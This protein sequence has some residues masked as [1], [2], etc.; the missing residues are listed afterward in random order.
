MN[1]IKRKRCAVY[2]R[3]SS[4]ERLD[5]SFNSIDA[6]REAGAAYVTSQKAEGWELIPEF[7][8]DPGFSGGN[9][10]RPGLKQLLTDIQASKIDIVVVYKIDRLSRS[11]ADF[12]KMVEVFD[13]QSVSF[14]S[15]TQQINSATSMGRLMLNVLLSFAQF[16]RE[17]TGERIRDKI[18]A[19]KRKGM[20]MGGAVPY[21][22]RVENRLLLT[23]PKEAELVGRIFE[24]FNAEKSMTKIVQDLNEQGIRTKRNYKFSKQSVY[25]ILHNR[26]YIGEISHKGESFP[27]QHKGLIDQVTWDRTQAILA[28]GSRERRYETW[29]KK[30]PHDFLLRGLVYT[31]DGDRL[32]T[33]AAKKPSGKIYRYYVINKKMQQGAKAAQSWN[34]LAKVLEDGVAEKLLE[35][36]RS[37]QMVLTHWKQIKQVNPSIKDPQTVV[38]LLRRTADI[39]DQYFAPL[40]TEIV[41]NLIQRVIIKPNGVEVLMRFEALGDF[42][43]TIHMPNTTYKKTETAA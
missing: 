43:K 29:D 16:E 24:R 26:T 14:S 32:L 22:Y 1:D 20:W 38:T 36:L 21:G 2:C 8:E 19:S 18:A 39:W 33:M 28:V 7:Y 9:M 35:Y 34:Y 3:V 10:N 15:V 30:N 5:Q 4:D 23:E 41:K 11:L 12:A 37:D 31:E 17:V 25:K 13:N 6:Q 40:K 42:V 27:G